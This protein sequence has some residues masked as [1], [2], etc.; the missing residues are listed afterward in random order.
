MKVEG[1]LKKSGLEYITQTINDPR[2]APKGKLPYIDDNGTIIADSSLIFKHLAQH[3]G[4]DFD[5]HLS[6]L[7]KARSHALTTMLEEHY[8][9][10]LIYTRWIDERY[11]PQTR[12]A[13]FGHLPPVVNKLVP[14]LVRK[15]MKDQIWQHGLGR[16][17]EED[18][19]AM[20]VEDLD[21][22]A[23]YLGEKPYLMGSKLSNA[24]FTALAFIANTLTTP[25]TSPLRRAIH[26][27]P[28]LMDYYQ[29]VY[30]ELFPANTT[31]TS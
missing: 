14:Q 15:G 10:S 28:I 13:F 23:T 17:N 16:H 12:E 19:Y 9:W 30:A 29:R 20:G 31:Q 24:D 25:E 21:T 2:G 7:D 5:Q 3:H 11:W 22:V 26:S 27:S 8:Y 18:I 6:P 1:V 4:I